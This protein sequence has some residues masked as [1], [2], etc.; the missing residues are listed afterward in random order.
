LRCI[1]RDTLGTFTCPG[2]ALP[3]QVLGSYS[4]KQNR[5]IQCE[6]REK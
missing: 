3:P 5:E 6:K 2:V 4:I 1:L